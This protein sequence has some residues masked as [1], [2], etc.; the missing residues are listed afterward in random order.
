MCRM[1]NL[2]NKMTKAVFMALPVVL[3]GILFLTNDAAAQKKDIKQIRREAEKRYLSYSSKRLEN[4]RGSYTLDRDEKLDADLMVSEGDAEIDGEV[5]GTVIVIDGDIKLG[6]N[7]IIRGDAIVITG[8]IIRRTGSVIGGDE[9]QTSWRRFVTRSQRT[10]VSWRDRRQRATLFYDSNNDFNDDNFYARYNRVEGLFMGLRTDSPDWTDPRLLNLY[11]SGGYGFKSKE[12]RYTIGIERKFFEV[13]NFTIGLKNYDLTDTDDNWRIDKTENTL[14]AFLIR[15]DFLDYYNRRGNTAYI[16]QTID[17]WGKLQLEYRVEEFSSFENSAAW[18]LF[19]G[20]KIFRP[21]P[22]ITEGNLRSINFISTIDTRNNSNQSDNGWLVNFDM[23]YTSSDIGGDYDYERYILDIR[24][25]Q[26]LSRY[27]NLNMRIML[28]SSMGELPVQRGFYLGGI[29]SLRGM[30]F[31]EFAG[32]SMFLGNIEYVFDPY[33]LLVGPPAWILEDFKLAAF[34]DAG[35]VE[36]LDFDNYSDIFDNDLIKHNLGF[37]LISHD[38]D[39]RIDFAWRTDVRNEK[40]R[41]T[42]RLNHSF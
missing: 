28:G 15:E 7:G 12:W 31:K 2:L 29:S 26:P 20:D 1:I 38:N 13:N 16:S 4:I 14:A 8:D 41:V 19:G 30:K 32:T 36:L 27:E 34:F 40:L 9:I 10:T 22:A 37:G 35:A 18:S 21:N 17:Y 39:F 25:F 3:M 11:G 23:E 6:R 5:M 33:R 42:F 24:R